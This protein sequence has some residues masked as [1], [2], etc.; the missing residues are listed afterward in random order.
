L[1]KTIV[2]GGKTWSFSPAYP[3]RPPPFESIDEL[4]AETQNE[5][6]VVNMGEPPEY[7]PIKETEFM[8]LVNLQAA[9]PDETLR[10]LFRRMTSNQNDCRWV[11]RTAA[12][13]RSRLLPCWNKRAAL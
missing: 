10:H 6:W 5:F 11:C 8:Q 12:R 13:G 7:D 9:E 4:F 3:K 2:D 1:G